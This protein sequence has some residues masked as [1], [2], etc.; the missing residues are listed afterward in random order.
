[1]EAL[2]R[3]L[4]V[5][6]SLAFLD[7]VRDLCEEEQEAKFVPITFANP[8]EALEY[9]KGEN[10]AVL[11]VDYE[12]PE[13]NGIDLAKAVHAVR[14]ETVTMMLTGYGE[15]HLAIDA[16][17]LG[18]IY[19]F[20]TKPLDNDVFLASVDRALRY[21]E[22]L[23]D[24]RGLLSQGGAQGLAADA[25]EAL[26]RRLRENDAEFQ[27]LAM[28]SEGLLTRQRT[29]FLR[30]TQALV[31]AIQMRSNDL[32]ESAKWV[33]R[34]VGPLGLEMN[35][36][37]SERS[38]LQI[39]ALLKDIGLIFL[40]DKFLSRNPRML[41]EEELHK[42][43]LHPTQGRR[44]L[45][46]LPGFGAVSEIV[47]E[48]LERCDGSGPRGMIQEQ[49][50]I[51]GHLLNVAN[52]AYV[53]LVGEHEAIRQN[54]AYSKNYISN[55]ISRNIGSLYDPRVAAM[56]IKHIEAVNPSELARAS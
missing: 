32:H 48:L 49:I 50:S 15:Q 21:A 38:H 55:H 34:F 37:P 46:A 54:V 29:E 36:S 26:E 28:E 33:A 43:R 17:N 2:P 24:A 10:V 16:L 9:V 44:F 52:D 1:M 40:G 41:R 39:A 14:P 42:Y 56:A 18:Y 5:D 4:V 35:L 6:D 12:M 51:P 53:V 13:M 7:L 30:A 23:A 19:R 8:L 47:G 31:G 3:V 20:L 22:R 45:A 11:V 25:T 27:T